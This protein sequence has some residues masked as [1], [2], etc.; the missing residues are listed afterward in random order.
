M[1]SQRAQGQLP[2]SKVSLG[3]YLSREHGFGSR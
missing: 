3:T 1:I 2:S